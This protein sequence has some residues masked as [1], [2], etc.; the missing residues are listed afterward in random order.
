MNRISIAI[1]IAI[2]G[3]ARLAAA[4]ADTNSSLYKGVIDPIFQQN[5]VHCH[6]PQKAKG[7]LRLDTF[8]HAIKGG[9]DGAV[10]RAGDTR[11][12]KLYRMISLPVRSDDAMP[13]RKADRR[14]T[15]AEIAAIR[16]WI[17][18]GASDTKTIK[19]CGPMPADVRPAIEAPT[20]K[21]AS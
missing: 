4:G 7:K 16:W 17:E 18:N 12:S 3:I 11:K 20:A 21:P 8:E 10:V 5:C 19:D 6:G 14:P 2:A 15:P 9:E 1:L 13:P